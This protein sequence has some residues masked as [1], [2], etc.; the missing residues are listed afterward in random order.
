MVEAGLACR[1]KIGEMEEEVF[2]LAGVQLVTAQAAEQGVIALTGD[3][4]RKKM[5]GQPSCGDDRLVMNA[6]HVANGIEQVE[7]AD[8]DRIP[9]GNLVVQH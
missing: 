7:A 5:M 1:T 8:S 6:H 4:R 3:F 9:C 2:I